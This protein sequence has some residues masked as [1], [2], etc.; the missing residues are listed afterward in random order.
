MLLFEQVCLS[1][2]IL[3]VDNMIGLFAPIVY[4]VPKGGRGFY[5]AI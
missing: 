3:V 5:L 2:L 1:P 4:I